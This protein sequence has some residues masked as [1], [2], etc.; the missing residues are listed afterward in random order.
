M[1]VGF[2]AHFALLLLLLKCLQQYYELLTTTR[3]LLSGIS[4]LCMFYLNVFLQQNIRNN[5][6]LIQNGTF[7][8]KSEREVSLLLH[9]QFKS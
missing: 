6:D 1:L 8:V 9:C 7:K 2:K 4:Q 3:Y 5:N